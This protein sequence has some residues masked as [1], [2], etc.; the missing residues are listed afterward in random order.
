MNQSSSSSSDAHPATTGDSNSAV[1]TQL[2]P[3]ISIFDF[4]TVPKEV[5]PRPPPTPTLSPASK[6]RAA[7]DVP[8]STG[9]SPILGVSHRG[10]KAARLR[11]IEKDDN[12][13][14]AE[15]PAGWTGPY[16]I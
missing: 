8:T 10:S 13:G 14:Q 15:V 12:S 2:K 7:D 11:G 1:D 16:G 6:K 4:F 3:H 5:L 9:L